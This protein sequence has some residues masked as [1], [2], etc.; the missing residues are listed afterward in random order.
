MQGEQL[1]E[2]QGRAPFADCFTD[3]GILADFEGSDHAPV[4]ADLALREQLPRG[5]TAP[6]IDLRNRRTGTGVHCYP[7]LAS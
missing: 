4:Y 3:A 6:P 7:V 5:A 2:E 1:G